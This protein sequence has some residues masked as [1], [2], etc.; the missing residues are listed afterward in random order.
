MPCRGGAG[1]KKSQMDIETLPNKKV[2]VADVSTLSLRDM[3]VV[4]CKNRDFEISLVW[5]RAIFLTAFLIGCFTAYGSV[6]SMLFK[7]GVWNPSQKV[8]VVCFLVT[9]VGIVISLLWI[10]MAK[11][12]KAWYEL[13]ECTIK[14]FV[15]KY[16]AVCAGTLVPVAQNEW[17]RLIGEVAA[18][19]LNIKESAR[20]R[21]PF[22]SSKGGAYSV[23][24]V[25]IFIGQ[26]AFCIWCFLA[27]G[28]VCVTKTLSTGT[29]SGIVNGLVST[30]ATPWGMFVILVAIVIGMIIYG[31][32]CLKSTYLAN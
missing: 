17:R 11:G 1:E 27:L 20:S 16:P 2:E 31:W 7:D 28:H 14:A 26:F 6:A 24:R 21:W 25:N 12:S 23:S 29:N 10:M 18:T 4:L 32:Y 8:N 9:L 22:F 13:Y 19:G 30:L 5:Q 15:V 3:Y